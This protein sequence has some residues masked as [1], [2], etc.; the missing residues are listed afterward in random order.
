LFTNSLWKQ[1]EFYL[2]GGNTTEYLF[3]W[4]YEKDLGVSNGFDVVYLGD[5][6]VNYTG[7]V[8]VDNNGYTT[9]YSNEFVGNITTGGSSTSSIQPYLLPFP[10]GNPGAGSGFVLY[11]INYG[12]SSMS[13][14]NWGSAR[15]NSNMYTLV[16]TYYRRDINP[17][18]YTY[19]SQSD[20]QFFKMLGNNGNNSQ[21][22]DK[23]WRLYDINTLKSV[24][25]YPVNVP[26]ESSWLDVNASSGFYNGTHMALMS[27]TQNNQSTYDDN[28]LIN[29][30]ATYL[31]LGPFNSTISTGAYSDL[32]TKPH[33]FRFK[34]LP[35]TENGYDLTGV[36]TYDYLPTDGG[37]DAETIRSTLVK[38][39]TFNQSFHL[40]QTNLDQWFNS[41]GLINRSNIRYYPDQSGIYNSSTPVNGW[42]NFSANIPAVPQGKNRIYVIYF[43]KDWY[44]TG[45]YNDV[46]LLHDIQFT[47]QTPSSVILDN[48][49]Y[50]HGSTSGSFKIVSVNGN[51][52]VIDIPGFGNKTISLS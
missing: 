25:G 16:N 40:I 45:S 3:R 52:I 20:I 50:L 38:I 24:L 22:T 12:S 46:V 41:D 35:D 5:I 39:L 10:I 42:I 44:S 13:S 19:P 18:D 17:N 34:Y 4:I 43:A 6:G 47:F 37:G 48:S 33:T 8:L 29:G 30:E 15:N 14:Y 26:G 23:V 49:G 11:N 7:P 27:S 31:T 28:G 51:S 9:N 2:P 1:A 32:T 21:Y 36:I